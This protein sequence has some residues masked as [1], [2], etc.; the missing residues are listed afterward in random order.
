MARY[1]GPRERI[2]RRIG[3][4]LGLKGERSLSPKS[5]TIK[6]MYP[7]GQH[8]KKF[9]RRPSEY[10]SQLRSKQKVR[11]IYRMLEKQFKNWT[12]AAITTGGDASRA[13][14]QRLER[15]LDNVLYRGGF[16]QSRDQA[17]QLINH[18]HILVN[19]RKLSIPSAEISQNDVITVKE[20]SKKSTFFASLAP[21]WLK[22]QQPPAWLVLDSDAL[23]IT[24]Q[25]LPTLEDSGL[26]PSDVASIIE[27]YSR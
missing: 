25:A 24:V 19:G 21:Q 22:K 18:G 17:R 15:R 26:E 6:R 27:Y 13:L 4:K 16:G 23:Q 10:A 12:M 2:E 20:S 8:G 5:A 11:N 1:T 14:V 3:V 9:G 7:P